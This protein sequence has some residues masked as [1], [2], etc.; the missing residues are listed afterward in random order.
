MKT[1]PRSVVIR[2]TSG[3]FEPRFMSAINFLTEISADV[4]SITWSRTLRESQIV[5]PH[6]PLIFKAQAD[7]GGGWK[8]YIS[9]LKFMIFTYT[10]LKKI[11]PNVIYACDL[12]TLIPSLIWGRRKSCLFIFDQFDPLSARSGNEILSRILNQFELVLS[13]KA[14]F[15][16]TPNLTRINYDHS[17]EWVEIKNIFEF[18]NPETVDQPASD[19]F[20][21]LYG[22]VLARDRGLLALSSAVLTLPQWEF[23]IFGQ[24]PELARLESLNNSRVMTKGLI[25]HQELMKEAGRADLY[26]ALYDPKFKHNKLTAS[27]KLFEAAQLGIPLLASKNTHIGEVVEEHQLGWTVEYDDIQEISE[28]LTNFGNM[29]QE[30]RVKIKKNL[31]DYFVE[32]L[33]VKRESLNR[34]LGEVMRALEA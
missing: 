23:Q 12:D 31:H 4:S 18:E 11:N 16:I 30:K 21:L 25:D 9:H 14:D 17:S 34:L 8:N 24:G 5:D 32:Q 2:S 6:V 10:S 1:T 19:W 20:Q 7:Y 22:G 13:K 29:G 3:V 26:A 28:V 27:N 33:Y 15:R